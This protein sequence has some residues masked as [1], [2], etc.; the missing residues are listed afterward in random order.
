[1]HLFAEG[2][3]FELAE[4]ARRAGD[5]GRRRARRA[6][7]G[8]GA[9]CAARLGGRR[10]QRLGRPP[11]P[12]AAARRGRRLGAV[13]PAPAA[14]ARSTSTRSLGADGARA[15][16]EGRPAGAASRARRPPPPPSSCDPAPFAWTDDDWMAR[17]G[18]AQALRRADL[19]L[20]GA[21]RLLAARDDGR[22]IARLG[23][24]WPTG[25]IPYVQGMGF[26]HIELLPIMEHPFGGSWG[27]QP[28]G[29]VR[30]DGA[31][32]RARRLRALRR[33]LRTRPASA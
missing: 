31:V 18:A 11:P 27:Y 32:R 23:P 10:L 5:G 26:T 33:P 25:S 22:R 6:L 1:M 19:D 20:R 29:A 15:A 21:C 9:E 12:D 3:H 24:S 13:H 2:R 16:A 28:L 17:R 14:R 4:S 8:L 30:A 7:R